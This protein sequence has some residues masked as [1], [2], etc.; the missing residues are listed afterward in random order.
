MLSEMS[1]DDLTGIGPAA[2]FAL[3]YL[4]FYMDLF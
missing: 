3:P 2:S 4:L 1:N